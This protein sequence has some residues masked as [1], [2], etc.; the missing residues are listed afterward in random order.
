M[1]EASF[2][3]T[4]FDYSPADWTDFRDHFRDAVREHRFNLDVSSTSEF[5]VQIW[6]EVQ[7]P[8]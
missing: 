4:E 5:W 7:T 2:Y 1:R 3:C 6:N 8:H